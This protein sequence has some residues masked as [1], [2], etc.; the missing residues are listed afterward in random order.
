MT[1]SFLEE[2]MSPP[3]RETPYNFIAQRMPSKNLLTND[4]SVFLFNAI[5]S[6]RYRGLPPMAYMS[7]T[8]TETSLNPSWQGV[9]RFR[10]K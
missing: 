6:K 3:M 7:L 2:E 5:S 8:F 1:I 4:C 10:L 9:I